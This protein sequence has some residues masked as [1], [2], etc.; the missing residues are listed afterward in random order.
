MNYNEIV[1]RIQGNLNT[2]NRD[3]YIPRRLILSIFKSKAE[4]IM[5]QRFN[6][7]SLFREINLYEWIRCISMEETDSVKCGKTEISRCNESMI[8]KKTL[9]S[10]IWSRYGASILMITNITEDKQYNIISPK[11]YMNISQN[12]HFDKFK[13][14]YAVIYPDGKIMIPDSTV[15]KINILLY[16]LDEKCS[17]I[18]D[19]EDKGECISYWD[20]EVNIPVKIRES[21]IQQTFQELL[22]RLQ[23]PKDEY[24]NGDSNEKQGRINE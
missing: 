17:E 7:K 20:K 19:C 16:S 1:S 13:G 6:D 24:P 2:L 8:S 10:L 3:V 21:I 4:F 23:L 14:K 9:P 15:E 18:S 22:P 11:D 12:K 5:S